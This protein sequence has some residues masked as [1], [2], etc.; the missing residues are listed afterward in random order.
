[1]KVKTPLSKNRYF[2]KRGVVIFSGGLDSTT[3][4]YDWVKSGHRE[5]FA[6]SIDYG[7]RHKH[8]LDCARKIANSLGVEHRIAELGALRSI[9]GEN[10]LTGDHT[11][12]PK[13]D[14]ARENMKATVVPNRNMIFMAVAAAWAASLKAE[15]I[16]YAAHSGDHTIYPDCR[17]AFAEAM[18]HA[19]SLCDWNLMHLERP[20]INMSKA[21]IVR[22]G[23]LLE[24]PYEQ[25][26]SCYEKGDVHCGQ[27]AT[28]RER[29]NAFI[30]AGV[31]DP[32]TYRG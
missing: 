5:V 24:I 32:T 3:L 31:A 13:A 22:H 9:F 27:C 25:T 30:R 23:S 29:K 8:E 15:V 10:A 26:W 17:P 19:I 4:L 20:Y 2:M 14:Y 11:H 16:G 12:V 21:D 18:D 7:Q 28:C 6:L 1:M